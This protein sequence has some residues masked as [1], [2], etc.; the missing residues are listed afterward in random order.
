MNNND[1]NSRLIQRVDTLIQFYTWCETN[2]KKTALHRERAPPLARKNSGVATFISSAVGIF[3]A[4]YLTAPFERLKILLQVQRIQPWALS[5]NGIISS[6][7]ST[8]YGD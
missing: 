5:G 7:K 4:E 8:G 2:V 1:N 3:I 6:L